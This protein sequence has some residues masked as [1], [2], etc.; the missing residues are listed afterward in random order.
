[1]LAG[2]NFLITANYQEQRS[3]TVTTTPC[4][5]RSNCP[6]QIRVSLSR[7]ASFHFSPSIGKQSFLATHMIMLLPS[8]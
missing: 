1:M 8:L 2:F 3:F 4:I 6:F 7:F 5:D